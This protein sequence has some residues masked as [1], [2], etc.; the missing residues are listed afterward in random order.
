MNKKLPENLPISLKNCQIEVKNCQNE[1]LTCMFCN[2]TFTLACSLSKHKK[3]C[4]EKQNLLDELDKVKNDS[5]KVKQYSENEKIKLII[6]NEQLKQ[7]VIELTTQIKVDSKLTQSL[8]KVDIDKN[9]NKKG[10]ICTFCNNDKFLS[11]SSV[12]RH[13]QSCGKK[14]ILEKQIEELTKENERKI[15]KLTKENEILIKEKEFWLEEKELL[16]EDR[17]LLNKDKDNLTKDKDNLTK[18]KDLI[19]KDKDIFSNLATINSDIANT[20]VSAMKYLMT[21]YKDTPPLKSIDNFTSISNK[22][23][24][25]TKLVYA[26]ISEYRNNTLAAKLSN[27][28]V[29]EYKKEDPSKQSVWSCDVGRLTYV[30]RNAVS[31]GRVIWS[32][33]KNGIQVTEIV[34]KPILNFIRPILKKFNTDCSNEIVSNSNLS[35]NK[36]IEIG[37]YQKLTIQ[38]IILIDNKTLEKDIIKY[39]APQ[40]YW[41]KNYVNK[42]PTIELIENKQIE[43]KKIKKQKETKTS[44]PPQ[45]DKIFVKP[46]FKNKNLSEMID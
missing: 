45:K 11:A 22:Y 7:K 6:E 39:M 46:K 33:D 9:D 21:Y 38:I 14:A 13:M 35:S 32:T 25:D 10:Y 44:K 2:V 3:R 17:K 24:D 4:K 40:F 36:L 20:S 1:D 18:D 23:E 27:H 16:L 29:L 41:N 15:E 30:I 26:L 28:L 34:I 37:E 31:D 43:Y 19:H 12:S 5:E 8:P 42:Q